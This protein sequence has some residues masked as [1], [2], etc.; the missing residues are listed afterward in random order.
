MKIN[1]INDSSVL[2]TYSN[3]FHTKLVTYKILFTESANI[4]LPIKGNIKMA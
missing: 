3:P 4:I 1:I 2:I